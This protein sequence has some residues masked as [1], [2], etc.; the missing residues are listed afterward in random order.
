[1][2]NNHRTR[3]FRIKLFGEVF[4]S[5]GLSAAGVQLLGQEKLDS[6]K[7]GA[8]LLEVDDFDDTH[9]KLRVRRSIARTIN[10]ERLK[11]NHFLQEDKWVLFPDLCMFPDWGGYFMVGWDCNNVME[12]INQEKKSYRGSVVRK[13]D[14][15]STPDFIEV[16]ISK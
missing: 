4:N 11:P 7:P 1:M 14:V 9:I 5:N 16:E 15:R 8:F 3:P 10:W 6:I 12:E 2:A 13:L